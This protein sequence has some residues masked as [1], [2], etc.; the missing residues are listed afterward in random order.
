M[1]E[2]NA[3]VIQGSSIGP[4]SYVVNTGDLQAVTPGNVMIKFADDT[5]MI[6]PATN[7]NSRQSWTMSNCGHELTIWRLIQQNM[8]RSLFMASWR[9]QYN[10]HCQCRIL[11]TSQLWKFLG[12]TFTNSLSVSEHIQTVIGSFAQTLYALRI[13]HA[14]GMDDTALQ[15]VYR[16]V[17]I[18]K[19]TYA[20]SALW[21]FTS[22][23]DRQRLFHLTKW[24]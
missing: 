11:H 18:A 9:Q 16:S 22:A 20:S 19:L 21:G 4:A 6:I 12:V 3:S 15:T 5:Y 24:A 1:S 17:I 10:Y 13:L 2:I 8:L 23:T 14:H 7:A